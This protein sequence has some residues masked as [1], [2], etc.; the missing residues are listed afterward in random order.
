[1]YV[2][3]VFFHHTQSPCRLLHIVVCALK[4]TFVSVDIVLTD[5]HGFHDRTSRCSYV[6]RGN[7]PVW[8]TWLFFNNDD[9]MIM[10]TPLR[11][12]AHHQL[13]TERRRAGLAKLLPR[14]LFR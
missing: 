8:V 13:V 7:A 4:P 9:S 11:T 6:V 2:C 10:P 1:M 3:E 5:T 12:R 14:L